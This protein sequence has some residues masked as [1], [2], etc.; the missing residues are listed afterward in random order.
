[1]I[2]EFYSPDYATIYGYA[3][4]AQI[5][6]HLGFGS[7]AIEP[8]A[9]EYVDNAIAASRQTDRLSYKLAM[10]IKPHSK[11]AGSCWLD[12]MDSY[13]FNAAIGYFVDK[14]EW[15]KGYA[16]EMVQAVLQLAFEKLKLHRVYAN[17][18]IGNIASQK[19]LE[20]IGFRR[21]GQLREHAL[22]AAGWTDVYSY[23]LLRQEWETFQAI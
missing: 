22:R 15:G 11:I 12:I 4:D 6:E 2:R 9:K 23:G 7:L 17:C 1:V 21:E 13:S 16:T 10:E 18:D 19:V 8:G 5:T 20:K 3:N 14:N